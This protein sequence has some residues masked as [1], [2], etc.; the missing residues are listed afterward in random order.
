M[1]RRL[2]L[3][4][5]AVLLLAALG[6]GGCATPEPSTP[7]LFARNGADLSTWPAADVRLYMSRVHARRD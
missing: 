1:T 6:A 2:R 7:E 3:F 4:L 5:A